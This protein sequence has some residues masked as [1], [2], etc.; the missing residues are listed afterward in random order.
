M[1]GDLGAY[2]RNGF[3]KVGLHAF[4]QIWDNGF[5]QITTSTRVINEPND[6]KNVKLRVPVSQ[7]YVSLFK[8]L[9]ASPAS[10][11]LGEVYTALQTGVVDGQE[12]PLIVTNTSKFYEVQKFCALSNHVWDGAW[13][14]ANARTWQSTPDDLRK[15]VTRNF[16]EAALKQRQDIAQLNA[17]LRLSLEKNG[18]R[19]NQCNPEPFREVLRKAG[20]YSEWKDKF[21]AS[22]W[23]ILEK[24]V[25]TLA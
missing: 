15:I 9:G 5:R 25:G 13:I 16:N 6:L 22:A 8:A 3:S 10:L 21:G 11:N 14:I 18:M 12:N 20:F 17:S 4:D 1:D 19:F 2:I 23:N 24:S 7:V